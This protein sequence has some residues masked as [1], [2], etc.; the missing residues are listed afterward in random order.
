M[1][2]RTDIERHLY[3]ALTGNR[4]G[5]GSHTL[6]GAI[7]SAGRHT[8]PWLKV[9]V[10]R[11]TWRRWSNGSQKPGP[12]AAGRLLALLR[13]D[14]LSAA[15]EAKIRSGTIAIVAWDNYDAQERRIGPD[16]LEWTP[17]AGSRVIDAWLTGGIT[18]AANAF[19]DGIG[20]AFFGE[21]LH[22]DA[23]G[24]SQSFDVMSLDLTKSFTGGRVG[25][26]GNRKRRP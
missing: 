17:A 22:P 6:A 13:R 12:A 10:S 23:H 26:R 2:T 7:K 25:R 15:R 24:S 9:G 3:R 14:R 8:K 19:Y 1:T 18:A 11:E 21:W 16:S 4:L 5:G 20:S